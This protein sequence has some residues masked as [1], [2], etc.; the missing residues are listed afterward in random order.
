MEIQARGV[1]GFGGV[2]EKLVAP[3][4]VFGKRHGRK[5]LWPIP[6]WSVPILSPVC[7]CFVFFFLL[8]QLLP[9]SK[10]HAPEPFS[11]LAMR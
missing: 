8:L 11:C 4:R 9:S 6:M 7:S 10:F 3:K 5:I 1:F 2:G